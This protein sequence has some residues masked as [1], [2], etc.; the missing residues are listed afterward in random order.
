M[1]LQL[2]A[3][4]LEAHGRGDD[5]HLV[6]MTTGELGALQKLANAHGGSLTVNPHTGLPEA[7]FLSSL[8]PTVAGVA[9]GAITGDPLLAAGIVGAGDYALTGSLGQGLMAGLGAWGGSSFGGDLASFS[10]APAATAVDPSIASA[11]LPA[12]MDTSAMTQDQLDNLK[13]LYN[14]P[15]T[16]TA[17]ATNAA[18][19]TA[20]N[21]SPYVKG[22]EGGYTWDQLSSG[23]KDAFNNPSQF[24]AQPGAKMATLSA[25]GGPLMAGLS[26]VN[27][28][29]PTATQSDNSNPMGLKVNP[30]WTGPTVPAQP[31][32][33]YKEQYAN[34]A[35]TPYNPLTAAGGG[36]MDVN[37]YADQGMTTDD[38]ESDSTTNRKYNAIQDIQK[39]AAMMSTPKPEMP[40]AH[41]AYHSAA[42]DPGIVAYSEE[43]YKTADPYTRAVGLLNDVR[44]GAFVPGKSTIAPAGGLGVIPTD[45]ALVAQQQI[46]EQAQMPV[47][48]KEGGLSSVTMAHGGDVGYSM[49]GIGSLGGY[50]DGGRLLKGP[51]DG[52]SDSIPAS[53]G[54][55]QPARLAEGEFVIPARIVSEL[56]NG[57]TDAGAKRLYAMMDRI[58]AKR[59]AT[60]DIAADTKAY[61]YLPA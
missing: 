2:A 48:S 50:S 34:Y 30:Q 47:T 43:K 4:H 60:K 54:H 17:A 39:G 16:Q 59:A 25:F 3:K 58:K 11:G 37:R 56:G 14:T 15:G 41:M 38:V 6:H 52:V 46:S 5:S 53:I 35:K 28:P 8:L 55:K 61:K 10:A 57:S 42:H 36:L 29:A 45:P 27:Q 20:A 23:A 44:N 21:V 51:G 22:T 7:G 26:A 31:N 40:S 9:L 49:G 19:T 12:G 13:A 18:T 33:Y 1:S 32:P 24:L